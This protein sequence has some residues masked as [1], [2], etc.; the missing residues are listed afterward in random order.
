MAFPRT[1]RKKAARKTK[2][3][4]GRKPTTKVSKPLKQAIQKIVHADMETKFVS[5][6]QSP[7]PFNAPIA[8]KTEWI[9]P[10]PVVYMVGTTGTGGGAVTGDNSTRIG[11][12]IRPLSCKLHVNISINS[13]LSSDV[14]VVWW[15][16]TS[17]RA[18]AVA[19][20]QNDP[21]IDATNFIDFAGGYMAWDGNVT[22]Y[23]A[24]VN[25]QSYT[26][27]AHRTFRLSKGVGY[28]NGGALTDTYVDGASPT[29]RQ[30]TVNIP[31]PKTLQYEGD[32]AIN[33]SNFCPIM[34][35]GYY[36][37]DGTPVVDTD[38]QISLAYRCNL[39]YK[40]A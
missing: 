7:T 6:V 9:Y 36:K 21:A 38:Q 20:V 2:G 24:P 37:P 11:D 16:F 29:S 28:L 27:L 34:C 40:D 8:A 12:T 32:L 4:K 26:V 39:F 35:V 31:V 15:L 14:N 17:K 25:R 23:G 30:F 33:P 3:R 5:R 18:K 19:S 22:T 13:L 1:Y 10:L